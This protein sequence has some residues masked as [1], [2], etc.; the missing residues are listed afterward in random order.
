MKSREEVGAKI[1]EVA[2]RFL[3]LYE[4]K[5][6][7]AWD[8]PD[9][10]GPDRAALELPKLLKSVGW[11]PGW[12]YCAAFCEAV[13]RTAYTELGAPPELLQKIAARLN[14]SVMESYRAWLKDTT[15]VPAPGAIFFMQNGATPFGHAGLVARPGARAFATIEG[16]TAPAATD[17]AHDRE[18]DGI[19]RRTRLLNFTKKREG[20]WLRAFLHPLP[21][22]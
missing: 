16:N 15:I 14:P 10:A 11:Q 8:N 17:A 19:F 12:P 13:W 20:L 4:T 18:G 3:N 6:N 2:S 7:A 21:I 1:L 5:A 9:T 22:P